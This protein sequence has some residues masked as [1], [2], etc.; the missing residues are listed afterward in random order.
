MQ[1][2]ANVDFWPREQARGL[3]FTERLRAIGVQD[4]NGG[5]IV[6]PAHRD[7]QPRGRD[8]GAAVADRTGNP[9]PVDVLPVHGRL[10]QV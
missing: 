8:P 10:E 1:V 3:L 5:R 6:G 2:D 7:T 9:S 4:A